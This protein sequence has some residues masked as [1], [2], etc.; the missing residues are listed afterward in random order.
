MKVVWF[1]RDLR[2]SDNVP[3]VKAVDSKDPVLGLYIVENVRVEQSD[4]SELHIS[5]DIANARE[6]SKQFQSLDGVFQILCGKATEVFQRLNDISKISEILCHEET[7]LLW[8]WD[9]DREVADWCNYNGVK[10][11]KK[12]TK[13]FCIRKTKVQSLKL[14]WHPM[15]LYVTVWSLFPLFPLF[16]RSLIIFI[17]K[18]KHIG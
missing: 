7:G 11:M 3:L 9:R 8:S 2:L 15:K 16:L 12:T 5:W 17:L 6:L 14:I 4:V 1:K 10:F 18:R 13:R